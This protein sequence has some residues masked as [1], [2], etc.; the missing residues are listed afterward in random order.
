[1]QQIQEKVSAEDSCDEDSHEDVVRHKSQG[2]L[3]L[4]W[5]QNSRHIALIATICHDGRPWT[6]HLVGTSNLQAA[7]LCLLRFWEVI[8]GG[9][10]IE[11]KRERRKQFEYCTDRKAVV[12]RDEQALRL[13][14]FTIIG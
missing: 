8:S 3:A 2:S 1:M 11:S 7:P 14:H 10:E 6:L 13:N 9:G 4:N 5:Q 12:E